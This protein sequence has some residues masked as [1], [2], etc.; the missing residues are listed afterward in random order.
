MVNIK[1]K[2]RDHVLTEKVHAL[3]R[4]EHPVVW[5]KVKSIFQGT[6][7]FLEYRNELKDPSFFCH[8][9]DTKTE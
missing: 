3:E 7:M 5:K 1:Q 9:E 6:E 4:Q 8:T 2:S